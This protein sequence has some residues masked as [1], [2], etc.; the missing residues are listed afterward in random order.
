[1]PVTPTAKIPT[2]RLYAQRSARAAQQWTPV[3]LRAA[4]A[5]AEAGHLMRLAD[6]VDAT[7]EDDRV[8]GTTRIRTGGL[9]R[10][11]LS[12]E[13]ETDRD[14][15]IQALERDF[16]AALPEPVLADLM[17]WGVHLGIGLGQ[18][19]WRQD[20][21]ER[22][23][24]WLPVLQVWHP[25]W[26]RWDGDTGRWVLQTANAGDVIVDPEDPQWWLFA[27]YG[28]ERPWRHA[29]V[30]AVA[31]WWLLKRFALQDWATYG[32]AHGN[33]LRA[34][35]TPAGASKEL[36][37]ELAEDLQDIAGR[38]GLVL[39]EGFDVKLVEATARTWE[40]FQRQIEVANAA[41][42]ITVLGQTL[43]TEVR[44]GSLAAAEIHQL[45]RHDLIENDAQTLSTAV[46]HGPVRWWALFNFG[47]AEPAAPW[48]VWD[49]TPPEDAKARAETQQAQALALEAAA[50][51]VAAWRA[52]GVALDMQAIADRFGVPVADL[53]AAA[54][55]IA[56]PPAAAPALPAFLTHR[57][58]PAA[59]PPVLL[60]SRD[61]PRTAAGFV[62]GQL[63]VEGLARRLDRIQPFKQAMRVIAEAVERAESYEELLELLPTL[64]EQIDPDQTTPL[65]E[66]LMLAD[67]AGRLAAEEDL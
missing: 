63:Y 65:M 64:F 38:T 5:A 16:W 53:E 21:A 12:F 51:A 7:L 45:V 42:A 24:R 59:P 55:A 26:L 11:P 13:S 62:R 6:L 15:V 30:R 10:L 52:M 56:E 50:R 4:Y 3:E 39:P 47:L 41:V 33:P 32:E 35:T 44:S 23:G 18:L 2:A 54:A 60:A 31:P 43:T 19:V 34:A 29:A 57:N 25:R 40:T 36:R 28:L 17:A 58:R 46:H 9:L 20:T 1:M 22:G 67:L 14:D 27:P 8:A 48:P 61:D 66:A 49:T 37:R